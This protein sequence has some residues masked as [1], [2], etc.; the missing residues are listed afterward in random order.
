MGEQAAEVMEAGFEIRI[1][2]R[3]L[4]RPASYQQGQKTDAPLDAAVSINAVFTA[5]FLPK[6]VRLWRLDRF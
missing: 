6:R 4:E 3:S 2:P 5:H 1:D